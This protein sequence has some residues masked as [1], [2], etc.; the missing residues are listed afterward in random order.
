MRARAVSTS[1][2]WSRCPE[3]HA[4][5]RARKSSRRRDLDGQTLLLLEDGH[6]LRDQALDVCAAADVQEKQDFRATRS[7]RCARWWPP[8]RGITL[9]PAAGRHRRLWRRARRTIVP[10]ARRCPLRQI[11]ALWRKSS[12]RLPAIEAVCEVIARNATL[13]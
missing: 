2:S 10:F 8:A 13:D 7:R 9:L 5:A 3:Q 11:G 12:A 4:L 6:C 1:P